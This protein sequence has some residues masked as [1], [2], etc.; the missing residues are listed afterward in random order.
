MN[1]TIG[2]RLICILALLSLLLPGASAAR[3]ASAALSGQGAGL[4]PQYVFP[5]PGSTR[6]NPQTRLIL[7]YAVP[8]DPARV[9]TAAFQ[10]RGEVSGLH[11]GRTALADDGATVSFTPFAPFSPGETVHV[12]VAPAWAGGAAPLAF[13]FQV[14]AHPNLPA[15][16]ALESLGLPPAA[17]PPQ[18][19]GAIQPQSSPFSGYLTL[20]SDFPQYSVGV[21]AGPQN[22][23]YIFL[24]PFAGFS[25][26]GNYLLIVDNTGAPIYYQ[27]MPPGAF[28]LDFKKQPN[29]LLSYFDTSVGQFKVMN[30]SYQVVA[31]YASPADYTDMHEL[32]LLPNNHGLFLA[33]DTKTI[34]MSADG[35]DPAARVTGAT[36]QE[37]DG[38]GNLV[39]EWRSWDHFQIADTY[40]PLTTPDIDYVHANALDLDWDG[41]YLLS[42]RH[43]S[44]ITKIDRRTGDILWRLGGKNNQFTFTNVDI[45]SVV[46]FSF[47]HDIR[48]LPNGNITLFDNRNDLTPLYSRAVEYQMNEDTKTI[49]QAWEYRS[50][51]PDT[52]SNAMGDAQRLA[53]G[54]TMIG[55]GL[56]NTWPI[57]KQPDVTEVTPDG[58]KVFELTLPLN[59]LNYR[60]FRFP[61]VGNPTWPPAAVY[62]T[63]GDQITIA[64]SWNGATQVAK[65][66]FYGSPAP[67]GAPV[68]LGT[69]DKTGFEMQYSF[70]GSVSDYCSFQAVP[71]DSSDAPLQS[72]LLLLTPTCAPYKVLVPLIN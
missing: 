18:A 36:V 39:F 1:K 59:M 49:T 42:S 22:Q 51:T 7:R 20:P 56:P 47:Q 16:S 58:S 61:W 23:G 72:S 65:Y 55:W 15:R 2:L 52:Y 41:N 48:R 5:I 30:S 33:Y 4:Q 66:Q 25:L 29:G 3:A 9:G 70:T 43:L 46:P 68:L 38:A 19:A 28:G 63:Q 8:A 67:S 50:S 11:P 10:V 57:A 64:A 69:L 60:A 32:Q 27:Q 71:L 44:E 40:V 14:D 37:L 34:D 45:S 21:P 17:Q 12:S 13:T 24:A 53:N 31:T 54:D 6:L 62:R 35:G 26:T